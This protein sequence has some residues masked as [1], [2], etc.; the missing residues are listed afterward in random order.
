MNCGLWTSSSGSTLAR[1]TKKEASLLL[2]A[3]FPRASHAFEHTNQPLLMRIEMGCE[4]LAAR[5]GPLGK[6]L[7]EF[8]N[9]TTRV[10]G[11]LLAGIKWVA[12]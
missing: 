2:F 11:L 8:L 9:A 4:P 6:T 12:A 10:N 5:A 1:A 7:T 3:F